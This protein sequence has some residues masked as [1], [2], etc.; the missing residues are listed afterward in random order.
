MA[1]KQ[2]K[3]GNLD[4]FYLQKQ[5]KEQLKIE[6]KRAKTNRP[7]KKA[8]KQKQKEETKQDIF[9]FDNE[10]VIGVNVIP[11]EKD[12][13]SSKQKKKPTPQRKQK[14]SSSIKETREKKPVPKKKKEPSKATSN[15]QVKK[16]KKSYKIVKR[17]LKL[18]LLLGIVIAVGIF[19][20]TTPLFNLSKIQVK[21]NEQI[22]QETIESLSGLVLEQNLFQFNKKVVAEKI[23]ENPYID[24]VQIKRKLPNVVEIQV[25]ERHTKY[26]I[27]L[28]NAYLYMNRQ[29][30]FL[31]LSENAKEVPIIK[32]IH[33]SQENLVPSSR[34][35]QTDLEKLEIVNIIM[36]EA[37]NNELEDSVTSID[38]TNKNNYILSLEQEGKIAYLGEGSNI[39]SKML[40]LKEIVEKEKGHNGEIFLNSDKRMFREQV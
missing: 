24:S 19:F 40:A 39:T 3:E 29:G 4:F 14:G 22:P 13:P 18:V 36:K 37:I 8:K 11:K 27:L 1:K 26:M 32:G 31:E 23:K 15:K 30:Y 34:L 28:G 9:D 2:A 25:K 20:M 16:E 38:M 21:G 12:K 17:V 7:S 5:P 10:I 6:K 35:D 33:T